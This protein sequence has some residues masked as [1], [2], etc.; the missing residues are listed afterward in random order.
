MV[1]P[2]QDENVTF[3]KTE[4]ASQALSFFHVPIASKCAG[5]FLLQLQR[6]FGSVWPPLQ[7]SEGHFLKKG[8]L[9]EDCKEKHRDCSNER[10]PSVVRHIERVYGQLQWSVS[11]EE[12]EATREG[13]I[14]CSQLSMLYS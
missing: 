13:F 2:Q 3:T 4:H 6:L 8:S 1:E 7:F 11:C 9:S 5:R 10:G 12:E 14:Y